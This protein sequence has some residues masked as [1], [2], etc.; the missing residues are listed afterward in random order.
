M[1]LETPGHLQ[2]TSFVPLIDK[3]DRNWKEGAL[4]YWP[5]SNR[6]D[7]DEN[8]S[9]ATDPANEQLMHQLSELLD[10]GKGW[11]EIEREI[12]R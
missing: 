2:G 4:S 3:P 5:V 6:T 8:R 9:I 11:K 7:P 1:G 12:D 10:R